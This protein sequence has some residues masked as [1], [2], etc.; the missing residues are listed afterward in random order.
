MVEKLGNERLAEA[1]H[2]RVAPLDELAEQIDAFYNPTV[3]AL[4]VV[5]ARV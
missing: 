4:T 5:G 2:L 1:H 3:R